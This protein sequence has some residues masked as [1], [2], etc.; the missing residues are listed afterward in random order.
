MICTKC[1]EKIKG[2][3]KYTIDIKEVCELCFIDYIIELEGLGV[4][5]EDISLITHRVLK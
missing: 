3:F 2:V 1:G 4:P 5:L